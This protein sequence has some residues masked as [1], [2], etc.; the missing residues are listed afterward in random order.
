M[1]KRRPQLETKNI[2]NDKAHQK[3]HTYS[4][5]RKSSTHEYA[6]K[7]RNHDKRRVQSQDTGDALAIKRPTT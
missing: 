3:M 4:K 5:G 7:I 6:T 2:T 1:E